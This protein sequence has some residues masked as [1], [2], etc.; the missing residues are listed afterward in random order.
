LFPLPQINRTAF[1]EQRKRPA[2]PHHAPSRRAL[3]LA[4]SLSLP[5]LGRSAR[6]EPAPVRIAVQFGYAYLPIT[7]ADKRGLFGKHL[8]AAGLPATP[9]AVQRINGATAIND[10][11]ISG[12]VEIGAYGLPGMLIAWEKTRGRIGV[13]GLAALVAGDNALFVSRP[14]LKS[15][16]DFKPADRIS[17][18]APNS[19]QA[20]VLR[21]AAEKQLGP[22]G[23][24]RFDTMMV[25]LAH[26][27]GI[28][29][30]LT[31]NAA[32]YIGPE[33]YM[34][35]LAADGR[36]RKLFDFSAVLGTRMTSGLLATTERFTKANPGLAA[37][38]V[39]ALDEANAQIRQ[40]PASAARLFLDSEKS[41]L[42]E[43]QMTALLRRVGG[44]FGTQPVGADALAAFMGRTG[45]LKTV[46]ASWR[47]TFVPPVSEQ[48]AA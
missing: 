7:L 34:T 25:G 22:D 27:D 33:P 12:N 24:R 20:I 16:A 5:A 42:D 6:A 8:A 35:A 39:G 47:E 43:A 29:A 26:P 3:L 4:A 10:A 48:Q 44:E 45:Q 46:P 41:M 40:D 9:F 37:A 13:K 18:T 15:L 32:G 36:V 11:L 19:Q 31:G 28:T 1:Q 21:M 14:D 30:L 23:T 38:V 2:M 17:V